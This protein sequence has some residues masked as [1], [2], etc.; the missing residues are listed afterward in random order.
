[1]TK[2][3][4]EPLRS[5]APLSPIPKKRETK[6][7][8]PEAEHLSEK[9]Y[10]ILRS[11]DWIRKFDEFVKNS[12]PKEESAEELMKRIG[13]ILTVPYKKASQR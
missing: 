8:A 1:M 5:G 12:S 2:K 13:I 11:A 6:R 9:T 4:S 10:E 3:K 7:N